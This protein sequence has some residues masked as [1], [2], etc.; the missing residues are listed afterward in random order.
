ML[1]DFKEHED[2]DRF[3]TVIALCAAPFELDY[4]HA[5]GAAVDNVESTHGLFVSR[6]NRTAFNRLNSGDL[7]WASS[8]LYCDNTPFLELVSYEDAGVFHNEQEHGRPIW[9]LAYLAQLEEAVGAALRHYIVP[10][11]LPAHHADLVGRVAPAVESRGKNP[12][13][14]DPSLVAL[15]KAA[16]PNAVITYKGTSWMDS[17]LA[18]A[19]RRVATLG[20][21]PRGGTFASMADRH[22]GHVRWATS[23]SS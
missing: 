15:V 23:E 11:I 9:R 17:T 3:F 22:D 13:R 16:P 21:A 7:R 2:R 8:M 18:A 4:Q 1:Q 20:S 12:V 10:R 5:V 19:N 6:P 14:A